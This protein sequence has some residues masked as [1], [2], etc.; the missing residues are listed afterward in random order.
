LGTTAISRREAG[1]TRAYEPANGDVL[2]VTPHDLEQR[3]PKATRHLGTTPTRHRRLTLLDCHEL[4]SRFTT[5]STVPWGKPIGPP[6]PT[7]RPTLPPLGG[8]QDVLGSHWSA[9]HLHPYSV[10]LTPLA[11]TT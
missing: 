7:T 2:K 1:L 3:E 5:L 8:H 4:R 10:G 11:P 6:G 9:P